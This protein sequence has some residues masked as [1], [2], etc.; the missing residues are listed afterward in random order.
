MLNPLLQPWPN[1]LPPFSAVKV[2][3]FVPAFEAAMEQKRREVAAIVD[4]PE[5]PTFE[6]TIEALED[7]GRLYTRVGSVFQ[8]WS[9]CLSTPE[10]QAI[11]LEL[12]PKCAVFE[13]KLTQLDGLFSR[14]DA[15]HS[16]MGS[17]G[18]LPEQERLLKQHWDGFVRE[19]A[20][21]GPSQKNRLLEIS[22]RLATLIAQFG[23]NVLAGEQH[24]AAP[25]VPNTRSSVSPLL[26]TCDDRAKRE[27]VWR[28]FV[29][30]GASTNPP[31]ISEVLAL[32][33]ERAKLLGY[34]SHVHIQLD[35]T[36][37]KT[38]ERVRALLDEVWPKA[39]QK[40][41]GIVSE[42]HASAVD[43]EPW[44]FPFLEERARRERF[45]VDSGEVKQHLQ[46]ERVRE[47][48]FWV[49]GELFGFAFEL[50][51]SIDV[52]HPD[53]SAWR[54]S[55]RDSGRAVGT[56]FFDPYARSGKQSGA[57][58]CSLRAQERFRGHVAP[59]VTNCANFV[60]PEGDGPVLISWEDAN[61]MFH[62]FG[63]ALHGLCSDVMYPSHSGTSVSRDYVEFPSQLLERWFC[64]PEV[65]SRFALHHVTGQPLP[66]E[67]VEKIKR[68]EV[69][70]Q[71][72]HTVAYLASAYI[73]LEMHLA[74]LYPDPVDFEERVLSRIG[75][76]REV[77]PW[78]RACHFGHIFGMEGYAAR[79]YCYLWADTLSAD[80]VGAFIEDGSGYFDKDVAKRLL[81]HV[82]SAGDS[83]DPELGYR[84]FRGRDPSTLALM[85][86]RGFVD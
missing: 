16:Q 50:D 67:L 81:K 7:C 44:D 5:A 36:M 41:A 69:F 8:T 76:P 63:H 80:A 62:E 30:R 75:M 23:Q 31:I 45:G 10:F 59:V 58:M 42:M 38:P 78:H 54:V 83:V 56:W 57:W 40:V 35:D 24:E 11:E 51:S 6:N 72:S 60:K 14:V 61:T 48:L 47:A 65:L 9:S 22:S 12:E 27:Q 71:A 46:L 37:A 4:N 28:S 29:A 43:V 55:D 77:S 2:E 66:L 15:V 17:L 32:R 33:R 64:S 39:R 1:G 73:D 25:G 49:A 68:A 82:F 85:K 70:N 53:V 18:L 26:Q 79:Y 34:A 21:L 19:G 20:A 13:L 84:A 52:Y 86:D 3:H 74:G